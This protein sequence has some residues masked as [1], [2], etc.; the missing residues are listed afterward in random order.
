L[1]I[2]AVGPDENVHVLC[3]LSTIE[4]VTGQ[5]EENAPGA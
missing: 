1:Q 2:D 4:D 3:P 5:L